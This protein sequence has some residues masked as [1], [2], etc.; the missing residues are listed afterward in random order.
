MLYEVITALEMVSAAKMR[1]AVASLLN[2]RPYA[3]SAWRILTNLA[4]AF[5]N[6]KH[7]FLEVREVR[8]ILILVVASDRGLC[9]SFNSQ[10]YKKIREQLQ[11]PQN[12]KVNRIVITSY[13]IHYTKLYDWPCF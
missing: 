2:M 1:R 10:L 13:S 12:L 5:E 8:N 11:N 3:H 4:R 9:G 7:G 6:Y